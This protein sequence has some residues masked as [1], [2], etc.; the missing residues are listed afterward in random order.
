MK[1]K[2]SKKLRKPQISRA[3]ENNKKNHFIVL[4]VQ[5]FRVKKENGEGKKEEEEY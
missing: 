3:K 2:D 5:R 1:Y 4:R